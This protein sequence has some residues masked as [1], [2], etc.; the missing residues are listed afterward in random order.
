MLSAHPVRPPSD[1]LQYLVDLPLRE[2]FYPMGYPV[3]ITTDSPRVLQTA[4][5]LW[6][7]YPVLTDT[8][9]VRIRIF[10]AA[11]DASSGRHPQSPRGQGSLFTIVH[12]P[13]DYAVADLSAGFAFAVLSPSS[14]SELS[15]FRYHFLE[16]LIYVML[17]ARHFVFVHASC[18]AKRQGAILLCGDSGAGKTCL[19][20]ACAKRGWDFVS[21]DAV[22]IVRESGD[23]AVIGRPYEIRFRNSA[24]GLFPELQWAPVRGNGSR[25]LDL[26]F[27]TTDLGISLALESSARH[28]VFLERSDRCCLERYSRACVLHNLRQTICFGDDD[29]RTR[30]HA[31]LDRFASLPAWRLAY[32]DLDDAERRLSML[33]E[34]ESA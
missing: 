17:A 11:V 29:C 7:R 13:H 28:I 14:L 34:G 2:R 33:L 22:H 19:A 18:V 20:Y 6:G 24:C 4:A 16:P 25:K 5:A 31:A 8:E 27:D 23:H 32:S 1:P 9:P 30:Q 21:G 15:Y 26:E 3:E 12:G 10:T